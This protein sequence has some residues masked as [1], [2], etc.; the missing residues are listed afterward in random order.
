MARWMPCIRTRSS[1]TLH[2]NHDLDHSGNDSAKAI[3]H[4]NWRLRNNEKVSKCYVCHCCVCGERLRLSPP[5]FPCHVSACLHVPITTTAGFIPRMR[6]TFAEERPNSRG[7][8]GLRM[9]IC[10]NPCMRRAPFET[11]CGVTDKCVLLIRVQ[12]GQPLSPK[13]DGVS[14]RY[15]RPAISR[16]IQPR[17]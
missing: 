17:Q 8:A 1:M 6:R 9:Q 13:M 15:G 7:F 2:S 11:V 4:R 14:R 12:Q 3:T 16:C 5:T 10:N